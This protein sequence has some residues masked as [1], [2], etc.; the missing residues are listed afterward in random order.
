MPR[1][2]AL[3]NTAPST[4]KPAQLPRQ[5]RSALAPAPTTSRESEQAPIVSRSSRRRRKNEM[6][7]PLGSLT[8]REHN[9]GTVCTSCGSNRITRLH[10]TL[11]NGAVMDFVS[12]HRC[13]TRVWHSGDSTVSLDDVIAAQSSATRSK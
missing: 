13:E 1:H 11:D 3:A 4:A 10:M 7:A 5:R 9:P 12:C 6:S 2:S 8:Q